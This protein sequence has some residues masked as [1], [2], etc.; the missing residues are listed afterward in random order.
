MNLLLQP[1]WQTPHNTFPFTEISIA[2]I[3]EAILEGIKS[4]TI[5]VDNIANQSAKPSFE[6]TIVALSTTGKLLE[7]ATT[8][9]Y[10]QLS[11]CTSEE[12]EALAERMSPLLSEHSSNIMLNEA[13]F[14]RVK[15]VYDEE[16]SHPSLKGEDKMLLEKTYDGFERSG[17]T[18]DAQKKERFRAIKAELSQTSLKFSQNNIK[19]TNAFFL[20]I[21]DQGQLKGLPQSQIEQAETAAQEKK[22]EGWVIT[23]HAPSFVP[24]MQYSEV[25]ELREQ[26]YRAYMTK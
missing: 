21:T 7:H 1:T 18:L 19:E 16:Q 6:N 23:L 24:F 13:L 26:L 25:R 17:A 15:S 3:E 8:L 11:A 12:L 20:H 9:M 22:L 4:E 2:D 14:A 10:N 5:E